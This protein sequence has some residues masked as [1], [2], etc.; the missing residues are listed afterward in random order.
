M[1]KYINVGDLEA[2]L[3]SRFDES[4]TSNGTTNITESSFIGVEVLNK[5]TMESIE[6]FRVRDVWF[7]E[8]LRELRFTVAK[9]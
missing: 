3:E 9:G 6:T 1:A 5:D 2:L 7:N 4:G 8:E